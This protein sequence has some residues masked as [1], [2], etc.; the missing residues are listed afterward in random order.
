MPTITQDEI[1][2]LARVFSFYVKFPKERWNE[3]KLA[4]SF[5]PE[6]DAKFKMLGKEFDEKYRSSE[7]V[8]DLHD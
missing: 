6:G 1:Q 7:N 8:S 2:G 4:E 5:T 3:I